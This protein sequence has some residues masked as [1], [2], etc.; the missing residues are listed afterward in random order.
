VLHCKLNSED[1]SQGIDVFGRSS[2]SAKLEVGQQNLPNGECAATRLRNTCI[3][4]AIGDGAEYIRLS[5]NIPT[6]NTS[7]LSAVRN[8]QVFS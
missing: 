1:S 3:S 4:F 8:F 7:S 5:P 2:S 6:F